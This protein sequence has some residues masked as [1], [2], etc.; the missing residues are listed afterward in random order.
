M[1][2]GYRTTSG[3]PTV[4]G[5]H[6]SRHVSFQS[7]LRNSFD[8]DGRRRMTH[9]AIVTTSDVIGGHE[10][11]LVHL[12]RALSREQGVT[13]IVTSADARTFFAEQGLPVRFASFSKP[14]KIWRQWSAARSLAT[15]LRPLITDADA[16]LVS[17]GTVEACVAPARAVKLLRPRCPVTAYIPMYVDR[18]LVFGKVGIAYNHLSRLFLDAID[19]FITINR[20]Q[21]H[22]IARHY[23][24]PTHV[25]PNVITPVARPDADHGPRLIYVGR[26]DDQQK[27]VSGAIALL[28]HP[29]NPFGTLHVFGDG[30]DRAL[31]EAHAANARHITVHC[32]GW[33]ARDCLPAVLGRGDVLVMNSRWEGEPMI[34]RELAAA[35]IPAVAPDIP[36]FRGL[37]QRRSRF[38]DQQSLLTLL[39][40]LHAERTTDQVRH[41]EGSSH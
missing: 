26:L 24:R 40:R 8:V 39:K 4:R 2:D 25:I 13:L 9:L 36:G 23:R 16:I 7:Q 38:N 22:L 37:L 3:P 18:A 32:H 28:D 27:N 29:D 33:I 21:A 17:G 41:A 14:G 35:G 20:I 15:V 19:A 30:P 10:M 12:A 34:V 6:E 31:V 1:I 11:Q 5:P